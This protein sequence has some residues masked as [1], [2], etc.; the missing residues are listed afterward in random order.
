MPCASAGNR[1]GGY[2]Q[3]LLRPLQSDG[4]PIWWRGRAFAEAA[5][6]EA[7]AGSA[8]AAH[9]LLRQAQLLGGELQ[10]RNKP[11]A[12][13]PGGATGEGDG[14]S[15][16]LSIEAFAAQERAFATSLNGPRSAALEG[17]Y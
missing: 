9:R 6:R 10:L 16:R 3:F 12:G 11:L 15:R 13:R 1:Q 4:S 5:V 17:F 2:Q 14:R 7:G 8:G